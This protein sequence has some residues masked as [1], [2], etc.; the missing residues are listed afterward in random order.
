MQLSCECIACLNQCV[1]RLTS[2]VSGYTTLHHICQQI[3]GKRAA[4]TMPSDLLYMYRA[5]WDASKMQTTQP[6]DA[7]ECSS[8]GVRAS[9][10]MQLVHHSMMTLHASR[11]SAAAAEQYRAQDTECNLSISWHTHQQLNTS[12]ATGWL[13]LLTQQL[14]RLGQGNHRPDAEP[15]SRMLNTPE[16]SAAWTMA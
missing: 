15:K 13:V 14:C 10:T 3:G 5:Q 11:C 7:A 1:S 4:G 2:S 6:P 12:R 8:A 16:S 9:L